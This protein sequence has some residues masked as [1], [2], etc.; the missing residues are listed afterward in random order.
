MRSVV[1]CR[2]LLLERIFL[3][4]KVLALLNTA[5]GDCFGFDI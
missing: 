3:D 1:M 5:R 4:T 2:R